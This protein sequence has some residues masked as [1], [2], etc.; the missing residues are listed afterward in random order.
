M[1]KGDDYGW[2][3]SI[4][5]GEAKAQDELPG[6]DQE[7]KD[8]SSEEMIHHSSDLGDFNA[9]R[10]SNGDPCAPNSSHQLLTEKHLLKVCAL[11]LFGS[12]ALKLWDHLVLINTDICDLSHLLFLL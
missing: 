5:S 12:A 8:T 4:M 2:I 10:M 9:V 7:S 6:L 11:S 1:E 3:S